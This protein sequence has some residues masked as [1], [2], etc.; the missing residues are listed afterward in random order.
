MRSVFQGGRRKFAVVVLAA[1]VATT[2]LWVKS[3]YRTDLF[4]YG[5]VRLYVIRSA[6]GQLSWYAWIPPRD[7]PRLA[8]LWQ[9]RQ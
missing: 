5:Y 6:E 2:A 7:Q 4:Q 9:S 8:M 3:L 1:T